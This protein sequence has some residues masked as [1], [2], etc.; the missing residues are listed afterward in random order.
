M[1]RASRFCDKAPDLDGRRRRSSTGAP[2][3]ASMWVTRT[4]CYSLWQLISQVGLQ[5]KGCAGLTSSSDHS[6]EATGR[7]CWAMSILLPKQS[8][9]GTSG[10]P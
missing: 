1:G 7:R 2:G 6:Q 10:R 8:L 5:G 3:D 4:A 9:P